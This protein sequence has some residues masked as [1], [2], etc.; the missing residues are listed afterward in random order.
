MPGFPLNT[1]KFEQGIKRNLI[2]ILLPSFFIFLIVK[3][4]PEIEILQIFGTFTVILVLRS[5]YSARYWS[6]SFLLGYAAGSLILL[7]AFNIAA[8]YIGFDPRAITSMAVIGGF[9]VLLRKRGTFRWLR[10]YYYRTIRDDFSEGVDETKEDVKEK[11]SDVVD[12]SE[13]GRIQWE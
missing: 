11:A 7:G 8:W 6:D 3:L 1:H 12:S 4:I 2:H 10:D 13:S 9:G 5:T